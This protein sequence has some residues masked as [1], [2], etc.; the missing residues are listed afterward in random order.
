MLTL[1]E[2]VRYH[3]KQPYTLG[4]DWTA[5]ALI[6]ELTAKLQ[7]AGLPTRLREVYTSLKVDLLLG[8]EDE[9]TYEEVD[10]E[11]VTAPADTLASGHPKPVLKQQ[12]LTEWAFKV[13][14][15]SNPN[16]ATPNW[17]ELI[18]NKGHKWIGTVM[19]NS[20]TTVEHLD[21][22]YRLGT[23]C[24]VGTPYNLVRYTDDG[25]QLTTRPVEAMSR[26]CC[27]SH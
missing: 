11:E 27:A 1:I 16:T 19:A 3:L 21:E 13:G 7:D 8:C 24:K 10:A 4:W 18:L 9:A 6:E 26:L 23:H 25:V 20:Y 5:E 15:V 2:R 14:T 12:T 17:S 22:Y